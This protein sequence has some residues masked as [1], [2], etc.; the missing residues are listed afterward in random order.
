MV[1]LSVCILYVCPSIPLTVCLYVRLSYFLI[2]KRG[3]ET[4]NIK[5]SNKRGYHERNQNSNFSNMTKPIFLASFLQDFTPGAI[6]CMY[7]FKT[8]GAEDVFLS[9]QNL[10]PR[11]S[12]DE[13]A[14]KL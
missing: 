9:I 3:F 1:V 13:K 11:K 4:A 7:F 2:Y 6:F 8:I 5:L 12:M 10:F 14:K